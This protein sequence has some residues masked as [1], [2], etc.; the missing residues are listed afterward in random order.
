MKDQSGY[1]FG[2]RV[3]R[4][5]RRKT[6]LEDVKSSRT[7]HFK[8][9]LTHFIFYWASTMCWALGQGASVSSSMSR[10]GP[11][12]PHHLTTLS[13]CP[14]TV[15]TFNYKSGQ[16]YLLTRPY[17]EL[18]EAHTEKIGFQPLVQEWKSQINNGT[19]LK[20]KPLKRRKVDTEIWYVFGMAFKIIA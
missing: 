16:Q 12:I 2:G 4:K 18:E 14:S 5:W 7:H 6:Q 13:L 19:V 15:Q 17:A 8:I 9:L 20:S 1:E 11:T 10:R 3:E